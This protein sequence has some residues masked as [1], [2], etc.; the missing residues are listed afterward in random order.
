MEALGWRNH[1]SGLI[2][3]YHA[4]AY[5]GYAGKVSL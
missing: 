4:P 1:S 3:G 2:A 5:L